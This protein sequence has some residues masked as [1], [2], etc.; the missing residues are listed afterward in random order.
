M[1]PAVAEAQQYEDGPSQAIVT[2]HTTTTQGSG[3]DSDSKSKNLATVTGQEMESHRSSA[4][5]S[6]FS[7]FRTASQ[8]NSTKVGPPGRSLKVAEAAFLNSILP[9]GVKLVP[10]GASCDVECNFEV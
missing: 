2:D 8:K 10:F 6:L 9:G 1:Q 7:S 4:D 3:T 5:S